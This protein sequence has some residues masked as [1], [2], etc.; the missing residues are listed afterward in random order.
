MPFSE[1]LDVV[2]YLIIPG[3]VMHANQFQARGGRHA[4]HGCGSN[5]PGKRL[6]SDP[7]P[8]SQ[9]GS[10]LVTLAGSSIMPS[11]FSKGVSFDG[12]GSSA[13]LNAPDLAQGC[14]VEIQGID[15]VLLPNKPTVSGSIVTVGAPPPPP[16]APVSAPAPAAAAPSGSG[17][18]APSGPSSDIDA[19]TVL[20][21]QATEA[22]IPSGCRTLEVRACEGAPCRRSRCLGIGGDNPAAA[23]PA[24]PPQLR[25]GPVDVQHGPALRGD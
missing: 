21:A 23:C 14:S 9:S 2:R 13:I 20:P 19:T 16:P 8:C 22:P 12:I 15:N 17:Q 7:M 10:S 3:A 11:A 6:I 25:A 24:E 1:L 18:G 4:V 5:Q